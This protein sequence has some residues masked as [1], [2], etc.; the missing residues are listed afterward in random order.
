MARL[1]SRVLNSIQPAIEF[2]GSTVPVNDTLR[3]NSRQTMGHR[4][5][6]NDGENEVPGSQPGVDSMQGAR[7]ERAPLDIQSRSDDMSNLDISVA[8][9]FLGAP[10]IEDFDIFFNNFPDVNFPNRNDQ[11]LMDLDMSGLEFE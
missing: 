5:S 10:G 8:N 3:P 11:L 1:G 6:H 9:P 2:Q 4:R 7:I